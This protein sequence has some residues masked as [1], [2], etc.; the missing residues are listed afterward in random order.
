MP[1]LI[2]NTSKSRYI[3]HFKQIIKRSAPKDVLKSSPTTFISSCHHPGNF[4]I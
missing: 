1:F 4:Q 2:E 3:F